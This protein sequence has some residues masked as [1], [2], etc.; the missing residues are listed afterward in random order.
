M[1]IH[2]L[3]SF[4]PQEISNIIENIVNHSN[5][6]D[7]YKLVLHDVKIAAIIKNYETNY[8][9]FITS[10]VSYLHDWDKNHFLDLDHSLHI[11]STCTCCERHMTNR[12]MHLNATKNKYRICSIQ[13]TE[14]KQHA[15]TCSC[16]QVARQLVRSFTYNDTMAEEDFRYLSYRIFVKR[17]DELLAMYKSLEE[18]R[19]NIQKSISILQNIQE[20]NELNILEYNRESE[21]FN[22]LNSEMSVLA[23]EIHNKKIECYNAYNELDSHIIYFSHIYNENDMLFKKTYWQI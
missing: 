9:Q 10:N 6:Y 2:I 5:H 13:L 14:G 11:L 21:K 17:K 16:R 20:G 18:I 12:P 1:S 23:T 7:T 22:I 4:F 15:C 19:Q 3:H 8:N